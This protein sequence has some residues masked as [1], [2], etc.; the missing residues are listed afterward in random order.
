MLHLN[1]NLTKWAI[2]IKTSFP[3]MQKLLPHI[4]KL[5]SSL[6]SSQFQLFSTVKSSRTPFLRNNS[7]SFNY[8]LSACFI[9]PTSFN[10]L[11]LRGTAFFHETQKGLD[12]NVTKEAKKV[13]LRAYRN[14]QLRRKL[15][16]FAKR[17]KRPLIVACLFGFFTAIAEGSVVQM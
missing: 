16:S 15:W 17:H 2:K 4:S 1:R 14:Y 10:F 11:P 5:P 6:L 3:N 13:D 8:P 7:P 12:R 9:F